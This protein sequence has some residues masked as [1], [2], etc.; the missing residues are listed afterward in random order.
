MLRSARMPRS[1]SFFISPHGFGHAARACALMEELTRLCPDITFNIFT[2][3][4]PYLFDQSLSG[5][6]RYHERVTDVG[7]V[8]HGP[9]HEDLPQTVAR[10]E[11]MLPF[12]AT[13]V[14]ELA[15]EVRQAR[16]ELVVCDIAPIGIAVAR[17]A[18]IPSVLVENFT[19]D[20][21]YPGYTHLEPR[22]EK[23]ARYFA[24]IFPQAT[25]HI[26]AEP[27]CAPRGGCNLT[28]APMSRMARLAP[29]EV[30]RRLGTSPAAPLVF[31]SMGGFAHDYAP[32]FDRLRAHSDM[33]FMIAGGAAVFEHSGNLVL[34]PPRSDFYHPDL[35][36]AS[37]AVV[38]KLGYSTVAEVYAHNSRIAYVHRP[39]FRE[40]VVMQEF[41]RSRVPSL[42]I[43]TPN[44][45]Q[46]SW[47]ESLADLVRKPVAPMRP[48][49]GA[50]AAAEFI[51]QIVSPHCGGGSR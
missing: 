29:E 24:E 48:P 37:A 27:V 7:L 36:S 18:G 38:S 28:V 15:E 19:W 14:A 8:Q 47:L 25:Y 31:L 23:H 50:Q 44:F 21:I 33:Q 10:L 20:G 39:N 49:N 4:T 30:H 2:A 46:G 34:L 41:V 9:L 35:V 51:L 17:Q 32:L 16:S 43:D 26:Q 5:V 42:L 13:L 12:R 11:E 40:S 45:A 22:L 6:Y 1:I 3:V